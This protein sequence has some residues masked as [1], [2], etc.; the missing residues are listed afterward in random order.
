MNGVADENL[1]QKI[2]S[3][4]IIKDINR[5]VADLVPFED[6]IEAEKTNFVKKENYV[7]IV[8]KIRVGLVCNS[9]N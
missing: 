7:K 8:T 1:V 3:N 9:S 5:V 6:V 2:D 4:F